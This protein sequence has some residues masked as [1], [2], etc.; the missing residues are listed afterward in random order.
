M[1]LPAW[2]M[3]Q[4]PGMCERHASSRDDIRCVVMQQEQGQHQRCLRESSHP[5]QHAASHTVHGFEMLR[6]PPSHAAAGPVHFALIC[7]PLLT[8]CAVHAVPPG[9]AV[10]AYAGQGRLCCAAALA[11]GAP[12]RP[13]AGETGAGGA[14]AGGSEGG[15]GRRGLAGGLWGCAGGWG[16]PRSAG[17]LG[18]RWTPGFMPERKHRSAAGACSVLH[19]PRCYASCRVRG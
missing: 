2:P 19:S 6:A 15:C 9:R 4:S 17:C 3:S 13:G 16:S 1:A 5:W 18:G 10:A 8:T 14:A 11:G 12:W 7:H